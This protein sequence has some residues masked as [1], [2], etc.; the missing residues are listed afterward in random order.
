MN[1]TSKAREVKAKINVWDYIKL[2]SFCSAKEIVNKGKRQPSQWESI[3]ASNA[4]HKGL[5]SKIYRE[6]LRLDNNEKT[7]DPIKRWAEDL[8]RHFSLEDIQMAH[9]LMKRCSISPAIRE[10]HIKLTMR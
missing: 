6:L 7:N 10:M 1:L 2:K 5:I 3:F 8:N 4:S 9:K